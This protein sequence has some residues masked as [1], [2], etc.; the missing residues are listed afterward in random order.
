MAFR[1]FLSFTLFSYLVA[2][3]VVTYDWS[4]TWVWANPDGR[5]ARPVIGIN[6]Q[7]PCPTMHVDKGD[8]VVV[9][10]HNKLG[11]ET[12]TMHWHGLY[13]KGTNNMDGPSMVTQCPIQPGTSYTYQ[14]NVRLPGDRG[15]SMTDICRSIKLALI[16]TTRTTEDSILM[17]CEG[18]SSST[19]LTFLMHTTKNSS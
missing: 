11:N 7:W 15:L 2:A 3:K 8:E 18:L 5:E 6:H 12:S 14:F 17:D 13:Q 1:F 19:I 10:I 4:L 9:H 16:G